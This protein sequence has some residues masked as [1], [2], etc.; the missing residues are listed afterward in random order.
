MYV[1][2]DGEQAYPIYSFHAQ[3][4][5]DG[6]HDNKYPVHHE[7]LPE[8]RVWNSCQTYKMYREPL[9]RDALAKEA[10]EWW[11]KGFGD[12]P[13][14][15]DKHLAGAVFEATFE[16]EG[17]WCPGWFSHWT[18]D[19]GQSDNDILQ[20]FGRFVMRMEELPE[21]QY[22]LMGAEDRWRW[23]GTT[24]GHA[25]HRTEP[26]CRCPHCKAAGIVQINH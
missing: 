24:D 16:R 25:D 13:R 3:W 22:C 20:S 11:E 6:V 1:P 23:C 9:Q 5:E 10:R 19:N 7:G 14:Y 4:I 21:G 18:F 17:T 2:F 15:R 26:P 12:H 8:G